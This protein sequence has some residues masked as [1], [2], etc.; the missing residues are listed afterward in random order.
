LE[1]RANEVRSLFF[2]G[3]GKQVIREGYDPD[4]VLQDIFLGIINRNNGSNP[5]NPESS[6]FG[7]YV[8]MVCRSVWLNYRERM[9][10]NA[11][12]IGTVSEHDEDGNWGNVDVA[13]HATDEQATDPEP[14]MIVKQILQSFPER[15]QR[16]LSHI[17]DG[18]SQR[19]VVETIGATYAEIKEVLERARARF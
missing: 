3:F 13:D 16:I 2:A 19:Y 10:R 9:K 14:M 11:K 17:I 12:Y 6:S 8:H 1:R 18:Q 7:H 4:E 15:E 5:Y